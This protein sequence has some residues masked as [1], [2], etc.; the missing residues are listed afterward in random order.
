VKR[1]VGEKRGGR[2]DEGEDRR[3]PRLSE[4]IGEEK[5]RLMM[6]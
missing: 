3:D 1:E 4:E 6:E 2:R 5:R